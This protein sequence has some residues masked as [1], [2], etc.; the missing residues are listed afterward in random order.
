MFKNM[1]KIFRRQLTN[2]YEVLTPEGWSDFDGIQKTKKYDSLKI[3]FTDGSDIHTSFNH[4]FIVD[5]KEI[6]SRK[7]NIG[8]NIN[9]KTIVDI[10]YQ[11]SPIWLYDLLDVKKNNIY[12]T[13]NLISHNCSFVGSA[14]TLID[15]TTLKNM[16]W[17]P[18]IEIRNGVN[19]YKKPDN[20]YNKDGSIL[21]SRNYLII[22]DIAEGKGLDYSAFSVIDVTEIPY[23]QVATF[24]SNK[25]SPL[26]MPEI[27]YNTAKYYNDA[28]VLIELESDGG[29]VAQALYDDLEYDYIIPSAM[30]GRKGQVL[31]A[32]GLGATNQTQLGVKMTKT[33]KKQGC[34]NIKDLIENQR[35]I[36]NDMDTINEFMNFIRVKQSFEADDGEHDDLVMG[37]VMFGWASNQDY[38]EDLTDTNMRKALLDQRIEAINEEAIPYPELVSQNYKYHEQEIDSD[39]TVWIAEENERDEEGFP[40]SDFDEGSIYDVI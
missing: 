16:V 1:F 21:Q 15:P 29:Q 12:Y 22:V 39:G 19:I 2:Q 9:H 8:D 25:I 10:S 5:D 35:I 7:L 27:I 32:T 4:K 28:N 30:R 13:D 23:V 37:L 26:E 33:V 34:S 36:I 6:E 31:G 11:H 20:V 17:F 40:E 18:P 3:S 24:R 38:F 14:G